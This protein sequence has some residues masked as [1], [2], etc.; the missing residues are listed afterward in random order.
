VGRV[1]EERL[2]VAR[3][4]VGQDGRPGR[5]PR[6]R[7]ARKPGGSHERERRRLRAERPLG[8][9]GPG[10]IPRAARGAH[11]GLD[12]IRDDRVGR[13][14][15]LRQHG[16][17]LRPHPRHL[18]AHV[19]HQCPPPAEGSHGGL[20]RDPHDRVGRAG[21]SGVV[22][23]RRELRSGRGRV[24]ADLGRQPPV[25]PLAPYGCVDRLEDDRLGRTR[26]ARLPGDGRAVRSRLRH[27]DGHPGDRVDADAAC[28]PHRGLGGRPYGDLRRGE[29]RRA[30]PRGRRRARRRH[31]RVDRA[32]PCPVGPHGT[33]R[34][35]RSEAARATTPQPTR[36]L[37]SRPRAHRR[38]A[39]TT[40]R[41]G[42]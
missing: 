36:G 12:R 4:C 10:R 26:F 41:S 2:G 5:G 30:G 34:R 31:E 35:T 11:G 13:R 17:T 19:R 6:P 28:L 1:P 21:Q 27:L 25:A 18:D 33:H 16:R 38:R 32:F 3:S 8:G 14:R 39:T 37:R 42:R 9:R 7:P 15:S 22:R 29:L 23:R 20:D 40:C 24:V